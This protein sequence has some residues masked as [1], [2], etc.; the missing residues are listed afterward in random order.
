V[1]GPLPIIASPINAADESIRNSHSCSTFC[2]RGPLSSYVSG[3][4]IFGPMFPSPASLKIEWVQEHYYA[5]LGQIVVQ[6]LSAQVGEKLGEIKILQRLSVL[7]AA[8]LFRMT[9]TSRFADISLSRLRYR[10]NSIVRP[11]G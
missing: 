3:L 10:P 1:G 4:D 8:C 6:E 9:S 5:E 2:L 7:G 11:I